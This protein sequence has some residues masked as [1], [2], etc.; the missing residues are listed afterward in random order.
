MV[1]DTQASDADLIARSVAEPELFTAVF[2]RHSAEILRYVYPVVLTS[3]T[4][5]ACVPVKLVSKPAPAPELTPK[6]K[7]RM[8][9]P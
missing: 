6:V 8:S 5:P 2:D 7:S 1:I 9:A 4:V 3:A